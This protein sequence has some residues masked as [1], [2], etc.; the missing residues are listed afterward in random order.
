MVLNC[1]HVCFLSDFVNTI[2][3]HYFFVTQILGRIG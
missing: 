1:I 2:R 3:L